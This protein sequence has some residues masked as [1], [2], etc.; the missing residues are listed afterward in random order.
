MKTVDYITRVSKMGD[1]LESAESTMTVEDQRRAAREAIK[2]VGA[3]I[4]KEH[5][6]L[7]ISGHIAANSP[8][9]RAAV[10]RIRRGEAQGRRRCRWPPGC[11]LSG[12][13][14]ACIVLWFRGSPK[15]A[16]VCTS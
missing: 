16:V 14:Y 1:R 15:G 9:Y 13:W 11:G 5:P 6:A 8:Q 4:G 7:D 3:R 10:D 12:R 2:G